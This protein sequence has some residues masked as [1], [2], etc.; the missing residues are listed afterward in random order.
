MGLLDCLLI[1]TV[2]L[3]LWAVGVAIGGPLVCLYLRWREAARGDAA[4]G[5]LGQWLA[6]GAVGGMLV[7]LLPGGVALGLMWLAYPAAYF[8]AL[9]QIEPSRFW[10]ALPEWLLSLACLT[11]YAAL[12]R[13]MAGRPVWH[14]LLAIVGGSNLAYHFPA[15]FAAVAV[16]SVR[17]EMWDTGLRFRDLLGE[18]EFLARFAHDVLAGFAAT[19]VTIMGFAY[20]ARRLGDT[21]ELAGRAIGV[22]GRV[23]L[24]AVVAQLAVGLW[25]LFQLDPASRGLL[26]GRDPWAATFFAG[27]VLVTV[28]L[29]NQLMAAALG[30]DDLR[31]VQR[32]ML[33]LT[34]VFVLMLSARHRARLPLFERLEQASPTDRAGWEEDLWEIR[35]GHAERAFAG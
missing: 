1:L 9:G 17:P 3:H 27:A 31:G 4:A 22:G 24:G 20:R 30:D 2:A 14:A 6:W 35:D 26:L 16:L 29:L 5:R 21:G 28:L 32:A 19:G 11:A 23:A 15:L 34:L 13:R 12:W 18:P 33:W 8:G 10:L 7:G 25:L